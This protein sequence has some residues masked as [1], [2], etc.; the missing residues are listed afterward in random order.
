VDDGETA[1]S[2]LIVTAYI[3]ATMLQLT[4]TRAANA[5]KSRAAMNGIM[6]EQDRPGDNM[7]CKGMLPGCTNDLLHF[8]RGLVGGIVVFAAIHTTKFGL[9]RGAAALRSPR[10]DIDDFGGAQRTETL[11]RT[12]QE[13]RMAPSPK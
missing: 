11:T 1:P 7:P 10:A 3:G 13:H 9:S 5:D 8:P 12:Y 4:P 6:H 2:D